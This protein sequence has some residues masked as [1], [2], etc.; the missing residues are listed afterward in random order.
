MLGCFS[1]VICMIDRAINAH[2][3]V[4]DHNVEVMFGVIDVGAFIPVH[5]SVI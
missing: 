1:I 3:N 2:L 5:H 4:C